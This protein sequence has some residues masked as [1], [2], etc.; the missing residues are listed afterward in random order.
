MLFILGYFKDTIVHPNTA[1]LSLPLPNYRRPFSSPKRHFNW[2]AKF[3]FCYYVA[4]CV[5][6]TDQIV[7]LRAWLQRW[8]LL[9]PD[10]QLI[11]H[12]PPFT[13]GFRISP[14]FCQSQDQRYWEGRLY[15]TNLGTHLKI[16]QKLDVILCSGPPPTWYILQT[17]CE[18][19]ICDNTHD[20]GHNF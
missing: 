2:K 13:A 4:A 17:D 6:G 7:I 9:K 18:I 5:W 3:L 12:A 16:W 20:F 14:L 1:L 8:P 11:Q 10:T 19:S 15:K